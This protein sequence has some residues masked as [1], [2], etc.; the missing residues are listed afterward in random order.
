MP[1][2]VQRVSHRL[3]VLLGCRWRPI[4][5]HGHSAAT[6]CG[7]RESRPLNRRAWRVVGL[8]DARLWR[9]HAR[10]DSF[11]VAGEQPFGAALI[12]VVDGL[13]IFEGAEAV[14]LDDAEVNENVFT[15]VADDEAKTFFRIKPFD[16]TPGHRPSSNKHASKR[17]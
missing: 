14:A 8:S 10:D 13:T 3:Q 7:T 11:H 17:I 12:V 5:F 9:R 16:G 1:A 6:E 4:N 2:N 15:F